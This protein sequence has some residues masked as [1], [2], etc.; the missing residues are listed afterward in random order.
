VT[1]H[2][3]AHSVAVS[4]ARTGGNENGA[5]EIRVRDDGRGMTPEPRRGFGL[6]GMR[7][8]VEALGGSLTLE[9]APGR[10]VSVA[11]RVPVDSGKGG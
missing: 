3:R 6:L 8:R 1:R 4:L 9:S 2:A 11:A 10:G 5:L 7:E